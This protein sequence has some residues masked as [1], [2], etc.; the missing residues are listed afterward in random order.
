MSLMVNPGRHTNRRTP[1]TTSPVM[2]TLLSVA[3]PASSFAYTVTMSPLSSSRF[4][5][6]SRAMALPRLKAMVRVRRATGSRR[7][8]VA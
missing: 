3:A 2:V 7:W 4:S 6:A 1:P 8:M 5:T